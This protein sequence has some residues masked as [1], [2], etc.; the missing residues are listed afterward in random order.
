MPSSMTRPNTT[1]LLS[2]CINE[3]GEEKWNSV[4]HAIKVKMCRYSDYQLS[5]CFI[6]LCKLMQASWQTAA[7][8]QP[9]PTLEWKCVLIHTL[10]QVTSVSLWH[11]QCILCA[12]A[13]YTHM[14]VLT[15]IQACMVLQALT[16][17]QTSTTH[18]VRL[19][20]CDE[21]LAAIAVGS[22][23]RLQESERPQGSCQR[24]VRSTGLNNRTEQGATIE[25]AGLPALHCKMEEWQTSSL[26][27]SLPCFPHHGQQAGP[28]VLGDEVF[29][30]K[31]AA[32]DAGGAGAIP[33]HGTR[34]HS[35]PTQGSSGS[36]YSL[37]A[38]PDS[39]HI[40]PYFFPKHHYS[41]TPK[42]E[43]QC[44]HECSDAIRVVHKP[45]HSHESNAAM[46]AVHEPRYS[47]KCNAAMRAAQK[48]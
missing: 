8:K 31:T 34:S 6:T 20:A 18:P 39:P 32:I 21:K 7:R 4:I 45:Q 11:S 24:L 19:C 22:G 36:P 35:V 15:F 42:P 13:S 41:S 17:I 47:H 38:C 26:F 27:P 40:F 29:V 48:P 9:N 28:S 10:T 44:A 16:L 46:R 33:L 25:N 30:G 23:I 5:R 14:H 43:P 1:C 37:P 2:I 12:T 3:G